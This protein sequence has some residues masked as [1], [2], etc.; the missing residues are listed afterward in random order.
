MKLLRVLNPMFLAANSAKTPNDRLFAAA[1]LA[2]TL[3]FLGQYADVVNAGIATVTLQ[4]EERPV[5]TQQSGE[6]SK[7]AEI[8]P[9]ANA[10]D[11]APNCHAGKTKAGRIRALL[12]GINEYRSPEIPDLAGA[13]N[14]IQLL[15]QALRAQDVKEENIMILTD[16]EATHAKILQSLDELIAAA[17]CGDFVMVHFSG[18]S[19]ASRDIGTILFPH[20]GK[21]P[22][23]R[24]SPAGLLAQDLAAAMVHMRNKGAT[25]FLSVDAC[26]AAGLALADRQGL[27]SNAKIWRWS[28]GKKTGSEARLL[29]TLFVGAGEFAA[30]YAVPEDAF[31]S[32][33]NFEDRRFGVFTFSLAHAIRGAG[34]VSLRNLANH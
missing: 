26:Y 25:V 17:S 5:A 21:L 22:N 4:T 32:E 19:Q 33:W 6:S 7:P 23:S 27:P 2:L 14:D 10:P 13:V 31:A 34:E 12:I 28:P 16:H 18:S 3:F 11:E 20:D 15:A 30:F 8:H 9:F 1:V 29:P 24:G